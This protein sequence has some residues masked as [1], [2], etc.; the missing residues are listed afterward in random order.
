MS[1]TAFFWQCPACASSLQLNNK[2]WSCENNHSFDCAKEGYVNLL[3]PQHK[4]SRAPGDNNEMVLARRAFLEQGHYQP[5]ADNIACTL[6][7]HFSDLPENDTIKLFDAGCGEGYYLGQIFSQLSTSFGQLGIAGIDI[8][9][10]AISK[11]AKLN[12]LGDF[13]VASS[14]NLPLAEDSQDAVIQIFAPSSPQ[15][16]KRILHISGIWIQVNPAPNHL[17][18]LKQMVYDKPEPHKLDTHVEDGFVLLDQCQLAFNV[19]LSDPELRKNLLMMTPFY[20]TISET[21][22]ARLLE[23]LTQVQAHF[24]IKILQNSPF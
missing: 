14:F 17:L 7:K 8:S 2:Q 11:A 1:T 22:K 24:D 6:S 3:L 21:K 5:L 20:W 4:K 18:A 15:E 23:Q 9:K 12:K 13:A 10:P 19:V 16:I